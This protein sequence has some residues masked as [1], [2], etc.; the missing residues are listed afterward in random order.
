MSDDLPRSDDAGRPTEFE[1]QSPRWRDPGQTD[2]DRAGQGE[3]ERDRRAHDDATTGASP[4]AIERDA[5]APPERDGFGALDGDDD[6]ED[7]DPL[8]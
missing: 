3:I 7:V 2:E 5:P 6:L 4:G 8:T 1:W